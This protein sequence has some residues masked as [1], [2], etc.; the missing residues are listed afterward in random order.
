MA[1]FTMAYGKMAATPGDVSVIVH[2]VSGNAK[3]VV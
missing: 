2:F 3:Y 1:I